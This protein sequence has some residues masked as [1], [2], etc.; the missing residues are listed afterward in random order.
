MIHIQIQQGQLIKD[1]E[2]N[3]TTTEWVELENFKYVDSENAFYKL[4]QSGPLLMEEGIDYSFIGSKQNILFIDDIIGPLE[5]LVTGVRLNHSFPQWPGEVNTSPIQIEVFISHYIY[6][7]GK[8]DL[9]SF[10]SMWV[11]T[12]NMPNPPTWYNRD[13]YY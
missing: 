3:S 12:K 9:D 10:P 8:L 7:A 11:T 13:R 5:T 2:I 4:D 6:E 1:G